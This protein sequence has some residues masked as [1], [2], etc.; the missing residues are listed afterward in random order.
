LESL[1][2]ASIFVIQKGIS[3][4]NKIK[5]NKMKQTNN[6]QPI[7]TKLI[8]VIQFND[9]YMV[10]HSQSIDTFKKWIKTETGKGNV[11][12][13]LRVTRQLPRATALCL[14]KAYWM[15]L[16]PFAVEQM[17]NGKMVNRI[18]VFAKTY[19]STQLIIEIVKDLRVLN[20]NSY[21]GIN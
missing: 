11:I 12:Q 13:V 2:L 3:P 15:L 6:T 18:A 4:Q 14:K 21:T 9:T 16:R 5:Q 1:K 19:D 10:A 7:N 20:T 8:C 17:D